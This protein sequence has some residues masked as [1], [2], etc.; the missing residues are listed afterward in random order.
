MTEC[1]CIDCSKTPDP[2][3]SEQYRHE[4]EVREVIRRAR[5]EEKIESYL[6]GIKQKRGFAAMQRLKVDLMKAW[7][8]KSNGN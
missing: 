7:R 1:Q 6:E 2:K 5:T 4:T 3:Y 8:S